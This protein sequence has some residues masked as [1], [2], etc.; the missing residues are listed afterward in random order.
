MTDPVEVRNDPTVPPPGR[1]VATRPA[2][3]SHGAFRLRQLVWLSVLVVDVILALRFA[4]LA[5]PAGDSGFTTIIY[6][7]GG[8]L[9]WPFQGVLGVTTTSGHPLQWVNILAIVV[10]TAAAW[11]VAMLVLIAAGPR[12]RGVPAY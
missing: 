1:R 9:A 10:Y 5:V 2:A 3:I 12:N 6:R 7:I 4:L 11:V 8:A